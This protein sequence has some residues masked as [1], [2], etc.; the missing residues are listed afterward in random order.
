MSQQE[1]IA[2]LLHLNPNKSYCVTEETWHHNELPEQAPS[3]FRI[4]A[5]PGF[6]SES[7]QIFSGPSFEACLREIKAYIQAQR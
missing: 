6:N 1:T 2:A 5:L 4:S 3:T 7:C